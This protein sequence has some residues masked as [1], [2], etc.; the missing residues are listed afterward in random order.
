MPGKAC[1]WTVDFTKG[2]GYK[3]PRKRGP[4][5]KAAPPDSVSNINPG[6]IVSKDWNI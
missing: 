6:A 1:L 5:K 2:D 3:R 4:T